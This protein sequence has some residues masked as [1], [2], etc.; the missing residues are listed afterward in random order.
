V[1][2]CTKG[3]FLSHFLL[4]IS[5]TLDA[6]SEVVLL[7]DG[8]AGG[9]YTCCTFRLPPAQSVPVLALSLAA[10][11]SWGRAATCWRGAVKTPFSQP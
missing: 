10:Q 4:I 9:E 5:V 11:S 2:G 7:H 8:E 6:L 1:L 3:G